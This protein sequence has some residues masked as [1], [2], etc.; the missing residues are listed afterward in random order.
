M[1]TKPITLLAIVVFCVTVN[2]QQKAS[3]IKESAKKPFAVTPAPPAA[4]TTFREFF[5]YVSKSEPSIVKDEQA[6]AKWLTKSLRDGLKQKVNS[7]KDQPDNPDFPG[8]TTFVGAWDAATTFT[9]LGSR[10]YNNRVV[11]DVWFAWGKNT[12]YEGDSRL[13]YFIFNLEDGAW[14]LDDVYT[15]NGAFAQAESL[16]SYLWGKRN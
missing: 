9:I 7:F 2:A 10:R 1:W 6:Q 14:K 11:I 8:N 13:S 3:N 16:N 5:A 12:N 15:F 4:L